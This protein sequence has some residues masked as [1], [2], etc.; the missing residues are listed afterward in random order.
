MPG[1]AFSN[2]F[3]EQ[4]EFF[5]N[6]LNLPSERYDDILKSAHD[7]GFIVAGAS[8]A[9]LLNDL[10]QAMQRRIEDGRGLGAFRKE[11]DAI[12]LKHGWTGWTGEGSKAGQAWRTKIIYQTNMAVSYAAGRWKQLKDPGLLSLRPYWRYIHADGV[13]YPRPL[14]ESWH[15]LTLPHDHPFWDTHFAPNGWGCNCRIIPVDAKEYAKAQAAGLTEPPAG[16]DSIDPKTGAPVGIDRGFDYAPG[17]NT[18]KPL[19]D[20]IDAKLINVDGAIG[21]KM[22]QALQPVLR[23]ER[24]AAYQ[25]FMSAVQADPVQRGRVAVVGAMDPRTVQWLA[26]KHSIAVATAEI[27]I[28]DGLLIGTN[29]ARHQLGGEAMTVGEWARLPAGLETPEQIL[30]DTRTGRLI[31]ILATTDERQSRLAIEFDYV[32]SRGPGQTNMIVSGAKVP[33]KAIDTEIKGGLLWQLPQA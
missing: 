22:Y 13:M 14:H 31:Y 2:P 10:H 12:V 6:K 7:R 8:N 1:V 18:T 30:F 32:L 16:W 26:D 25:S 23:I 27:A 11:F 4:L 33:A 5:R 19:K 17:A 24:Q 15:G 28:H 21:A 29:A 3:A 20:F 9:D